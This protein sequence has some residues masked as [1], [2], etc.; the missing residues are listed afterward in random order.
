MFARVLNQTQEANVGN[1]NALQFSAILDQQDWHF[2]A[3]KVLVRP[4]FEPG[5][6]YCMTCSDHG[7]Q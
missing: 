4:G 6:P 3:E 2:S 1:N 5:S 7:V